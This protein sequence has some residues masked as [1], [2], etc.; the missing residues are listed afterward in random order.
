M[1]IVFIA[2][3]MM[4][5]LNSFAPT[6]G[7][8]PYFGHEYHHKIG[9]VW[10][11]LDTGCSKELFK[12]HHANGWNFTLIK[13]AK[14]FG[15]GPTSDGE[16]V[17]FV[18]GGKS[19]YF[20]YINGDDYENIINSS[21]IIP[22]NLKSIR[23]SARVSWDPGYVYYNRPL[24]SAEGIQEMFFAKSMGDYYNDPE[25]ANII[26]LHCGDI[27]GNPNNEFIFKEQVSAQIQEE[28]RPKKELVKT[29]TTADGTT[30]N[31]YVDNSNNGGNVS[32][33]GNSSQNQNQ[34]QASSGGGGGV[35]PPLGGGGCG[36]TVGTYGYGAPWLSAGISASYYDNGCYNTPIP[37]RGGGCNNDWQVGRRGYSSGWGSSP[38]P[39]SDRGSVNP[40]ISRRPIINGGGL[41]P[42]GHNNGQ[43]GQLA[44]RN[45][46]PGNQ[47]GGMN[48]R[49]F[50]RG[51][52]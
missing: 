1:K 31:V 26:F 5:S 11:D 16:G 45:F 34:K 40:G 28:G 33:S 21:V 32:N 37:Q 25:F 29:I 48:G 49:G 14:H 44:P 2:I 36:G 27:C 52:Q 51:G 46:N 3:V 24:R 42:R 30:I 18:S 50:N 47:G 19:K 6:A 41:T 43:G 7:Y 17:Q 39:R 23:T 10:T 9:D 12:D 35:M 38:R 15:G 8:N 22:V 13:V 4:V 20:N